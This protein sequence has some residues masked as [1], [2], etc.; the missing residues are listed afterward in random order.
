[1]R[2]VR[3]SISGRS[4][5][6]RRQ[7]NSALLTVAP[8]ATGGA[9]ASATYGAITLQYGARSPWRRTPGRFGQYRLRRPIVRSCRFATDKCCIRDQTGRIDIG[10]NV[11]GQLNGVG[12]SA[13]YSFGGAIT[14]F[15]SGDSIGLM[16]SD[17]SAIP[18]SVS[19]NSATN[20]LT[21]KDASGKYSGALNIQI[22]ANSANDQFVL[23]QHISG[24]DYASGAHSGQYDIVLADAFANGVTAD[25][26][27]AANWQGGAV[28]ASSGVAVIGVST[29]TLSASLNTPETIWSGSLPHHR[30]S[31]G[32]PAVRRRRRPQ[33]SRSPI[34]I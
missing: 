21:I 9:G 7:S 28:P 3:S 33:A 13:E 32:G 20:I 18:A 31:P 16:Q 24:A 11:S 2:P 10:E 1:M 5:S 22:N 14:N 17:A 27:T 8:A 12:A 29:A 23:T 30:S 19:Y 6:S 25:F 15:Q 34:I 26:N 4:M